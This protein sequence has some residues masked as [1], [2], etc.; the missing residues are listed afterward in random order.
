MEPQVEEFERLVLP[1]LDAAYTLARYLLRDEHDAQ[2]V[3]Q[4]AMLRAW[5]HFGGYAGGSARGWLLTIVR[6]C[7]YTTRRARRGDSAFV[8]FDEATHSGGAERVTP[9]TTLQQ[10]AELDGLQEALDAL[11]AP[12]REVLI[13][14]EAQGL[15]YEEIARVIGAPVGTVMSRLARARERLR[16]RLRPDALEA[17]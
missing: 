2:D 16:A 3:V 6:H 17:S 15:T 11:P 14:R 7:C 12:F 13:L 4:D 9:E 10:R 5:R 8:E 1:H